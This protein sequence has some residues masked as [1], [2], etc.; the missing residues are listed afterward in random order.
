MS[1]TRLIDAVKRGE[2]SA[3]EEII[4]G[5]ADVNE[6]DENGWTPLNW[7]AGRGDVEIARL[8]LDNGA[9]VLKTGRDLRTPYLIALAAGQREVAQLLRDAE[10]AAQ[11]DS[12]NLSERRYCCAYE[13]SR[14][15]EFPRW[16]KDDSRVAAGNN[17]HPSSDSDAE[18][19]ENDVV[20]VHQD[21]TVTRL[22]WH[23]EDVIFDEVTPEWKDFCVNSLNF[24]VPDDLDLIATATSAS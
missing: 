1:E 17:G 8:L 19:A 15:R 7:A 2:R 5:G 13:I 4:S 14:L 3:V 10:K 9:D 12:T 23:N 21:F 6:Q 20:Y 16:P 24:R 22:I 18:S 11:G